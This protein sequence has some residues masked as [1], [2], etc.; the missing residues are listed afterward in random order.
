MPDDHMS[1]QFIDSSG[2]SI[3]R[4]KGQRVVPEYFVGKQTPGAEGSE[5]YLVIH[6]RVMQSQ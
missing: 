3:H 4:C 5:D 6:R 1:G 2:D